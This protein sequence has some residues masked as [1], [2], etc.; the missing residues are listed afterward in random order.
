LKLLPGH[1]YT[2]TY[3]PSIIKAE[4]NL[5]SLPVSSRKCLMPNEAKTC[6]FYVSHSQ[7]NCKLHSLWHRDIRRLNCT[8]WLL[9]QL[10]CAQYG[11]CGSHENSHFEEELKDPSRENSHPNQCIDSC[12]TVSFA[13]EV[14]G[15]SITVKESRNKCLDVYN[16]ANLKNDTEPLVPH[17]MVNLL[18]TQRMDLNGHKDEIFP[19][20]HEH[21]ILACTLRMRDMI[22]LTIKPTNEQITMITQMK[23][24]SFT[25][26]LAAIGNLKKL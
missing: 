8:P 13:Y 9:P 26:Q 2:L 3:K 4:R 10:T 19:F 24:V 1:E 14:K 22:V 23:R 25:N 16:R 12:E 18:L 6:K 21:K 15:K 20:L 11:I 5:A 17:S 7:N